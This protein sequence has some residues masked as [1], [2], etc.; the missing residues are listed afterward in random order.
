[1]IMC[2]LQYRNCS[3]S[4]FSNW[5]EWVFHVNESRRYCENFTISK[6]REFV[7]MVQTGLLASDLPSHHPYWSVMI[8]RRDGLSL[9]NANTT[10]T[11]FEDYIVSQG[12]VCDNSSMGYDNYSGGYSSMGK[13]FD[14]YIHADGRRIY[15]GLHELHKP[16]TL[17]SPRP[18]VRVY[19]DEPNRIAWEDCD[20]NMN[21]ILQKY[22]PAE[23][24]R[25]MY[26]RTIVLEVD[27]RT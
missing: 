12:F 4:D 14:C 19:R 5:S 24:F 20:D 18:N 10:R 23:I 22:T 7:R 3:L 27:L 15:Y 6:W 8:K 1:M 2:H 9:K 11:P 26:D 13:I 25:A 21:V 17:I 16:P